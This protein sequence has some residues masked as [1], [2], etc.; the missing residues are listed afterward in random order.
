MLL[1]TLV[2][3]LPDIFG[4]NRGLRFDKAWLIAILLRSRLVIAL[5]LYILEHSFSTSMTFCILHCRWQNLQ[6]YKGGQY[7]PFRIYFRIIESPSSEEVAT[8]LSVSSFFHLAIEFALVQ[9]MMNSQTS[10]GGIVRF[11]ILSLRS[12]HNSL[13]RVCK[14]IPAKPCIFGRRHHATDT[15]PAQ[16][17]SWAH[18][19]WVNP[20]S[21][22]MS[23]WSATKDMKLTRLH[24]WRYTKEQILSI[25]AAHRKARN[26]QDKVAL[27]SVRM[28]RWGM[29]FVT[30]Y[31]SEPATATSLPQ[32]YVMTEEKWITRFIFLESVAGVPGM[33]AGMLRH[34]KSIRR[35]QRDYGW[36][37]P[38]FTLPNTLS[39]IFPGSKPF[40]KKPTMNECTSSPF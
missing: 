5:T 8:K 27:G 26:W 9:F 1:F 39:D 31:R 30:G 38:M 7:C 13:P 10:L 37:G 32:R 40:L 3:E 36:W 16:K 11:P 21:Q 35:F 18:P 33:V 15:K 4:W 29:D 23:R 14:T 28:L 19:T 17:S 2:T 25:Q 20:C 12:P 34:L 22:Q 6:L 24:N